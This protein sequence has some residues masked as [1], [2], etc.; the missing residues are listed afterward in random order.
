[1]KKALEERQEEERLARQRER[2]QRE[3]QDEQE[4]IRRKEVCVM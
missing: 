4:R 2:L 3:Y 1:M